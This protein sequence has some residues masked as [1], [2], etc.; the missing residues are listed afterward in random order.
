MTPKVDANNYY[1]FKIQEKI[2]NSWLQRY[3]KPII[4][5]KEIL[6]VITYC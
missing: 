4:P 2:Y 5:E 1:S 3:E 6:S